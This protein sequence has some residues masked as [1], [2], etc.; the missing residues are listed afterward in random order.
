[1]K[2]ANPKVRYAWVHANGVVY[3]RYF[4][5]WQ[6]KTGGGNYYIGMAVPAAY[7]GTIIAKN[8][9][10]LTMDMAAN[11]NAT[12]A[13][14][15]FDNDP[16]FY[17]L[18]KIFQ[19][20]D[21]Y[22][23]KFP[24]GS[25]AFSEWISINHCSNFTLLGEKG[26]TFFYSVKGAPLV[27]LT[28]QFCPNYKQSGIIFQGNVLHEGFGFRWW[29]E[30]RGGNPVSPPDENSWP[31]NEFITGCLTLSH[32]DNFNVSAEV[33]D[34]YT[35]A[36]AMG[37]LKGGYLKP[38]VIQKTGKPY[39]MGWE[40]VTT[41]GAENIW[42]DSAYIDNKEEIIGGLESFGGKNNRFTNI[43]AI[44]A[45]MSSNTSENMMIDGFTLRFRKN[46]LPDYLDRSDPIINFNQNTGRTGKESGGSIR[47]G[48]IIF[49]DYLDAK[50]NFKPGIVVQQN[51]NNIH[52]SNVKMKAL[53]PFKEG[54]TVGLRLVTSTGNNTTVDHCEVY[55]ANA[56]NSPTYASNIGVNNGSVT[57]CKA[58][59]I[60]VTEGVKL[61]SNQY[62]KLYIG[63]TEYTQK[64]K[65]K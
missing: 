3:E 30:R 34:T 15:Y 65:L 6:P 63:Y 60:A 38:R 14:I 40:V 43:T 7:R 1:L 41:D 54:A 47:N 8:G 28:V 11:V 64:K 56:V 58:T 44:N 23:L 17:E 42:I 32:S 62:Q 36:I 61:A 22:T 50:G 24:A 13:N 27:N 16:S 46:S 57:N 10:T 37:N 39:Y 29:P 59:T 31:S 49:D 20:T 53:V 21:G 4:N 9:N 12:N 5:E 55:G 48:E 52:I 25:F 45:R 19:N 18:M 35:T 2:A 26:K 33:R 51:N